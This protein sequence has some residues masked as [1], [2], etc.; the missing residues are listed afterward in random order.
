M[1]KTDKKKKIY[2]TKKLSDKCRLRCKTAHKEHHEATTSIRKDTIH[3][4]QN[5][6]SHCLKT[7]NSVQDK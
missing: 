2:M 3:S 1:S 5:V 6:N 4:S 7:T